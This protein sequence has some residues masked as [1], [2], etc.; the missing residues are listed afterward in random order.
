MSVDKKLLEQLYSPNEE[1]ILKAI[2]VIKEKGNLDY[3]PTL[4]TVFEKTEIGEIQKNITNLLNDIKDPKVAPI[5]VE[6]IQKE[7][8]EDVLSM[9]LTSC[10][11]SGID[12]APY[13]DVFVDI[14]IKADYLT[15]FEALTVIDNMEGTFDTEKMKLHIE[16][17]KRASVEPVNEKKRAMMIELISILEHLQETSIT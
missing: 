10:W 15:A 11:S 17:L 12:Y 1:V 6:L 5:F 14:V 16:A 3:I 7:I 13:I 8:S 2:Q 4:L 9:L